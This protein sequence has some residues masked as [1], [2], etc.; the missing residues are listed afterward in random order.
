[1]VEHQLGRVP[2]GRWRVSARCHLGI[3]MA[4]ESHPVMEDGAPFPTLFWLTCPVLAKRASSLES[5]GW[6]AEAGDQLSASAT[7]VERFSSAIDRYRARRDG[8]AVIDDRGSTPGG[9]PER[10][11]CVHAHVAHE[12]SDPPNPVGSIALAKAGWPDCRVA[13][14][15]TPGAR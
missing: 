12:L 13:C 10:V 5:V 7:L 9:G 3:P 15:E 8:H 11:K 4:I 6:M 2:R 14:F 1:M